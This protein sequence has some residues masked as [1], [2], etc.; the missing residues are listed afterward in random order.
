M[1]RI[2]IHRVIVVVRESANHENLRLIGMQAV[3]R[4]R[5]PPRWSRQ[6]W[7]HLGRDPLI[8]GPALRADRNVNVVSSALPQFTVSAPSSRATV[9]SN[10]GAL[11]RRGSAHSVQ[12]N[13]SEKKTMSRRTPK[14]CDAAASFFRRPSDRLFR[15]NTGVTNRGLGRIPQHIAE[16][17]ESPQLSMLTSL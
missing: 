5:V 4:D 12:T 17:P 9:T 2:G 15:G 3:Q 7:N 16:T 14:D 11:G 13:R 10:I 8:F 1:L 6:L